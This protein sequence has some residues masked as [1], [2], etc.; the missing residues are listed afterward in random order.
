[1][2]SVIRVGRGNFT[3][4][5]NMAKI[6]FITH[7]Y[8]PAYG[9]AELYVKVLA[10]RYAQKG[11]LVDVW[12]TDALEADA[13]WFG[14]KRKV[15][16]LREKLNG[17]NIRRFKISSP[18]L[19]SSLLANI[20]RFLAW[21]F[22]NWMVQCFAGPPMSNEMFGMLFK[23]RSDFEKYD[24][25][26]VSAMPFSSIFYIG[27]H[28]SR[29]LSAKLY[30]T[31][32]FHS[33]ISGRFLASDRYF[34]PRLLPFYVSADKIFIQSEAERKALNKFFRKYKDVDSYNALLEKGYLEA[35]ISHET[36][37]IYSFLAKWYI[38]L[39]YSL[40]K[41]IK[42][43]RKSPR[44]N[45]FVDKKKIIKVGLGVYPQEILGGEGVLFREK[46]GL[47]RK[48]PLVFQ[49]GAKLAVKGVNDLVEAMEVLWKKGCKYKLVLAGN[50]SEEFSSYWNMKS[51]LVRKNTVIID[52]I[53]EKDKKNLYDAGD[54]YVMVSK[55]ESFGIVYLEAW[56]YKKPVIACDIPV[57]QEVVNDGVDGILVPFG[58]PEVLSIR[59]EE[60]LKDKEARLRMGN[61][62]YNKVVS[63]YRWENRFKILDKYFC[64][65]QGTKL[66]RN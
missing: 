19:S 21:G 17:V 13:L 5:V 41:L 35:K 11:N 22:P 23:R 55:S 47:D 15:G 12:T 3:N 4:K 42:K 34:N 36:P 2:C 45:F 24:I 50:P 43:I 52:W 31:P 46:Y 57:I 30:L 8:Y 63:L 6:L 54:V 18:Y 64:I 9:G 38:A 37:G 33:S 20:F 29:K 40:L 16:I 26:H 56:L 48:I 53:D 28:I 27:V 44:E 59:I 1:V 62:G 61:N 25:V 7:R 65:Y 39:M 51:D 58:N 66:G 14:K 32:F 10:E 60:L 49:I